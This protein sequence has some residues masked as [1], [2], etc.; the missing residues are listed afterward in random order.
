MRFIWYASLSP[1]PASTFPLVIT[2]DDTLFASW[3]TEQDST[4]SRAPL[5]KALASVFEPE[6]VPRAP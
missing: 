5:W 1:T 2:V 4:V 6:V 3:Q